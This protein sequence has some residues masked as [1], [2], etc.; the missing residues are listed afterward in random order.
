MSSNNDTRISKIEF[1]K[2]NNIRFKKIDDYY[3][4]YK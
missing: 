2:P 1:F 3:L 4:F